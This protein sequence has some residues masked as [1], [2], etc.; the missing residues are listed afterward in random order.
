[1]HF[2]Y[3]FQSFSINIQCCFG[4]TF[5]ESKEMKKRV[6]TPDDLCHYLQCGARGKLFAN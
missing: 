6:R 5:Y 2:L 1:M 4:E 3:D